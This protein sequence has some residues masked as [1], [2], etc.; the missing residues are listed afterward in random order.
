AAE[1]SLRSLRTACERVRRT[2]SSTAQTTIEIDSLY[3]GIDFYST[4]TRARFEELNM[5]L[6]RKCMEPVEKCLRDAKMDKNSIHDVVLVGG[7]TRI[8]KVQQLLQDFFNG[9]ELC[10]SINADEAVSFKEGLKRGFS[11][12]EKP[13]KNGGG[14]IITPV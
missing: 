4:I 13:T 10:K 12:T 11:A 9:K 6:F 7:S 3:E 1:G 2:L 14:R 8:P 5:D